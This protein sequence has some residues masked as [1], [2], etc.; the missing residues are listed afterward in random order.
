MQWSIQQFLEAEDDQ[1]V[2]DI[3]NCTTAHQFQTNG[4]CHFFITRI[5]KQLKVEQRKE[6]ERLF[7]M[8]HLRKL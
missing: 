4:R 5:C 8:A 2:P 1:R 3:T 6:N 7:L